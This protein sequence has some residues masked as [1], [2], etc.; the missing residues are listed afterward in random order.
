VL[1]PA[2]VR[3]TIWFVADRC[4]STLFKVNRGAV[5]VRDF[6]RARNLVLRAGNS[7]VAAP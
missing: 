2:T 4:R 5:T 1:L 6:P 7:Y 3:G